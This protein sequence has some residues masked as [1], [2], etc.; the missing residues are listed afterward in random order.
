MNDDDLD[1]ML[2]A[3]LRD[4]ADAGF[5]SRVLSRVAARTAWR[6]RLTMY[7]PVAAAAALAPFLPGAQFTEVA[8]HITPL[9][10]NS[11]ALSIAAAALVLTLSLDQRFRETA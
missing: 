9:I 2:N 11:G 5:S 3:P 8:L 7:A 6:E 1:A 10:A 4:V